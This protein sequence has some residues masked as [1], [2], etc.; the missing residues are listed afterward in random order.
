M[1]MID[2][3]QVSPM[4][5]LPNCAI[6]GARPATRRMAE[7]PTPVHDALLASVGQPIAEAGGPFHASDVVPPNA[8]PRVRFLRAYRV[9]D[10]WLVWVEKGG[11][12]HDFRLLAFRDAAKG[13][14]MSVPMPQ[15]ASRNLCTASRAMAKV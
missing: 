9:R 5:A 13:V 10:L 11:I 2:A 12:G 3:G 6:A 7:L 8:P 14:S 15:D 4:P 1:L